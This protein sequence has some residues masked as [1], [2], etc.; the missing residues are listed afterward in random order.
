[1]QN[2]NI[3]NT[4]QYSP[5]FSFCMRLML[6]LRFVFFLS[7]FFHIY[8]FFFLVRVHFMFVVATSQIYWQYTVNNI[9]L[10]FAWHFIW[11][12]F[13]FF[14]SLCMISRD[15][16]SI[17]V[18]LNYRKSYGFLY[19]TLTNKMNDQTQ[20]RHNGKYIFDQYRKK[21]QKS[22]KRIEKC[23]LKTNTYI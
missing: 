16:L 8:I 21:H 1:M 10:F 11:C 17:C 4:T 18:R 5:I 19:N 13:F 14:S 6:Y 22:I 20:C 2:L 7:L 9:F 23:E 3:Y 12:C 15:W